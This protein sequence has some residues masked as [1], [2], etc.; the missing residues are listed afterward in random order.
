MSEYEHKRGRIVLVEREENE[1]VKE[2]F[3][4]ALTDKFNEEEWKDADGDIHEFLS[5][6]NLDDEFFYA[7]EKLY[8]AFDVEDI[9]PDDDLQILKKDPRGRYW[10][11]MKYYN[12][13]T[14]LSQM[15][16]EE[17]EKL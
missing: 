8:K 14:C 5:M 11:E 13:V 12:G 1:T 16:E 7:K 17:L 2:Y 9:D 6:S 3:K 15:V 4:K 10:F